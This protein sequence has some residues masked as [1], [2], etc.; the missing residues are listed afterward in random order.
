MTRRPLQH[1][2]DELRF[3]RHGTLNLRSSL[4]TATEAVKRTESWLRLKQAEGAAEV[5]VITGRGN[6]SVGGVSVVREAVRR[7]LNMLTTRGVVAEHREHSPGSFVVRLL[8]LAAASGHR[9][10]SVL[11]IEPLV[12]PPTLDGLSEDT[13]GRLRALATLALEALG[14]KDP[15]RDFIQDEMLR[16][17]TQLA[18]TLPGAATAELREAQFRSAIDRAIDR[19]DEDLR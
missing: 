2:L 16:Q 15:S 4:P 1:A 18:S 6:Q 12:G 8:S 10:A 3:G 17:C 9:P 11:A 7:L 13:R 19:L 5:L 14:L